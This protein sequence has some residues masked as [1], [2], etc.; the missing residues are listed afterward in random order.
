MTNTSCTARWTLIEVSW[1]STQIRNQST[2]R[3]QV[4]FKYQE[5]FGYQFEQQQMIRQ[6]VIPVLPLD[7][8][9]IGTVEEVHSR[10]RGMTSPTNSEAP[11]KRKKVQTQTII[12]S[13]HFDQLPRKLF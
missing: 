4:A 8:T 13:T 2:T 1:T 6:A 12:Q 9:V 5:S 3:I 11:S 10:K 7:P